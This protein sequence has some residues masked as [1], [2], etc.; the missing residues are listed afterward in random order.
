MYHVVQP[1][2]NLPSHKI[3]NLDIASHRQRTGSSIAA[4]SCLVT[5]RRTPACRSCLS[6]PVQQPTSYLHHYTASASAHIASVL[7]AWLF[8]IRRCHHSSL[9]STRFTPPRR[10]CLRNPVQ[11]SRHSLCITEQLQLRHISLQCCLRSFVEAA[12]VTT[13]AYVL[14][15]LQF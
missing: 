11:H 8:Q 1:Q 9:L 12:A 10:S 15:P 13:A 6:N 5:A 7:L 14:G 2:D 4:R 3:M